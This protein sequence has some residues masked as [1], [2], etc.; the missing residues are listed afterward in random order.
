MKM[1]YIVPPVLVFLAKHPMVEKY[2][3]SSLEAVFVGAAPCGKDIS[4]ELMQR[5]PNIKF[6]LQG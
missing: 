2:D 6:L 3:L 5:L 1:I 4:E